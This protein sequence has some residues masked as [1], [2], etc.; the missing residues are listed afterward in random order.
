MASLV[1]LIAP[2]ALLPVGFAPV[3][4]AQVS[5]HF[6]RL[7]VTHGKPYVMV[8]VNGSGPF[9]FVVNTGTG[10]QALVTPELVDRLSLP[11]TGQVRLVDPSGLGE[12]RE[13]LVQI[14]SLDVAG[15]E[16]AAIKAVRHPLS[17]E[18]GSCLGLLGFPLFR[19][20]L[21]TLDYPKRVMTLASGALNPDGERSVLPFRMPD[22]VPIVPLRI[23]EMR[24]EAEF[25]SGGTGLSLP[26]PLIG[27]IK[28]ASDPV[29]FGNGKSL[30]TRFQVKAAKLADDVHLGRYRFGHAVVEI[31]PAF[32]MANFGS[33][34]IENFAVTFDQKDLLVRLDADRDSFH[35]DIA[36]TE[37]RM[38]NAPPTKPPD[39]ALVP[40]G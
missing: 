30:V 16:F 2:F 3:A 9:R 24:I 37:I 17:D 27:R 28:L 19:D 18:D 13:Q 38:K 25:D 40:V 8:M 34:G 7:E 22:G 10:A 23:G 4:P 31:N 36:P 1:K 6:E 12:R 15:V 33:Q 32:P 35:L 26:E 39:Q 5:M 21:L 20:Y 29:V 11:V 14:D